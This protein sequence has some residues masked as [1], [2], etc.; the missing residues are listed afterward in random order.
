VSRQ[1]NRALYG[2]ICMCL[3]C[4]LKSLKRLPLSASRWRGTA[5][6]SEKPVK[7]TRFG[8]QIP[9]RVPSCGG[10]V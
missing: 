6:G 10:V 8:K 3:F 7:K 9:L 5:Y 1:A 2:E 4:A